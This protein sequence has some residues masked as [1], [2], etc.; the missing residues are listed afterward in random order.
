MIHLTCVK[1]LVEL[2]LPSQS[3]FPPSLITVHVYRCVIL[4]MV[5]V[6]GLKVTLEGLPSYLPDNIEK[7]KEGKVE[8]VFVWSLLSSY[9][10][11]PL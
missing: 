9:L 7:G 8:T 5:L 6:P 2:A 1:P 11:V 3:S 4:E 10:Q